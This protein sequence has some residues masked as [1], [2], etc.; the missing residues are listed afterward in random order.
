M[1]TGYRAIRGVRWRALG[2]PDSWSAAVDRTAMHAAARVKI[3]TAPRVSSRS[4]SGRAHQPALANNRERSR[5]RELRGDRPGSRAG[6]GDRRDGGGRP[7]S[8]AAVTRRSG[9]PARIANQ[10]S[11][12]RAKAVARPL[13]T[14]VEGVTTW[15]GSGEHTGS[16]VGAR[17]RMRASPPGLS[18]HSQHPGSCATRRWRPD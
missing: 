9:G 10:T 2:S 7:R 16:R 3:T 13:V 5:I 11:A 1:T 4:T 17:V 15:P 8:L 14:T 6:P 18:R 12:A